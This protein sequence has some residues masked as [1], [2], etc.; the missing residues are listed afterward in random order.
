MLSLSAAVFSRECLWESNKVESCS[1]ILKRLFFLEY[2]CDTNKLNKILKFRKNFGTHS[3]KLLKIGRFPKSDKLSLT[4]LFSVWVTFL[5]ALHS[6]SSDLFPQNF[7]EQ[8][9]S[10]KF[11]L[12]VSGQQQFPFGKIFFRISLVAKEQASSV[13]C[14]EQN[15][16]SVANLLH[17][18]LNVM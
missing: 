7:Y 13:C 6:T 15:Q 11:L 4:F 14:F 5:L 8:N 3:I 1:R 12:A 16:R 9:I 17:R 2:A 10:L 18:K